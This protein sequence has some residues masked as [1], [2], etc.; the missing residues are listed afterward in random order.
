MA[1]FFTPAHRMDVW[2]ISISPEVVA[3][4]VTIEVQSHS[5]P[6]DLQ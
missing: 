1:C 2:G 4:W 3:L 6:L 5:V